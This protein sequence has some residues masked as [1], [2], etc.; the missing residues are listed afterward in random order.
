MTAENLTSA[1]SHR[2]LEGVSLCPSI[3]FHAHA[4]NYDAKH[5]RSRWHPPPA[6]THIAS[7]RQRVGRTPWASAR[8]K[9]LRA[10]NASVGADTKRIAPMPR[11]TRPTS[12]RPT[13]CCASGRCMGE[14]A[15]RQGGKSQR[16]VCKWLL[17][18]APHVE[19]DTAAI[20]RRAQCHMRAL[21]RDVPL[22]SNIRLV[23]K[24]A[25]TEGMRHE[26]CVSVG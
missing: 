19:Q 24:G 6:G 21:I 18:R 10:A 2:I 5:G 9:T 13:C 8:R 7:A 23:P 20:V 14:L 3:H 25:T 17:M 11:L 22:V 4:Q 15:E 26:T 16:R 12:R 1:Q